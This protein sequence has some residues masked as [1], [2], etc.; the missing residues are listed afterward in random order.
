MNSIRLVLIDAGL[1]DAGNTVYDFYTD[2]I[3]P[4]I[5]EVISMGIS[6]KQQENF[7]VEFI[8]FCFDKDKNYKYILVT[9]IKI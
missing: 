9:G 6:E 8:Q 2:I 1:I 3:K 5:G 4:E 7:K